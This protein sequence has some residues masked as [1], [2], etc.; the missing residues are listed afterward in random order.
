MLTPS[1]S[2]TINCVTADALLDNHFKAT[3]EYFE[4]AD[5][6]SNLVRSRDEFVEATLRIEQASTKCL[7][8]RLALE[9]HRFRTQVHE[10]QT[11]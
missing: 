10:Q 11:P 3:E 7:L 1:I 6:L 2:R 8:T 5:K 4:A 9:K